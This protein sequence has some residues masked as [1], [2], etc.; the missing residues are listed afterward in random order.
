MKPVLFISEAL[1][2]LEEIMDWYGDISEKIAR[3]FAASLEK[4]LGLVTALPDLFAADENGVRKMLLDDFPYVVVYRELADHLL[5]V[6]IVHAKRR[7]EFWISR[8]S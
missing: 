4:K 8:I 7:S 3:R 1:T 2:D 6:A 5:V